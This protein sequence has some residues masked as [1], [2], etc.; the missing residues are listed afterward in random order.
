MKIRV[1]FDDGRKL[2]AE[3]PFEHA[4]KVLVKGEKK[5]PACKVEH[6][7]GLPVAGRHNRIA[8][9]DTYEAEAHALCCGAR[10]GLI[11]VTVSTIFGLEE[12]E[13]VLHHGRCRVY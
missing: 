4:P 7:E 6:P 2:A 10:I 8:S 3:P 13:L 12:D 9:H 1:H 11:R 5:C